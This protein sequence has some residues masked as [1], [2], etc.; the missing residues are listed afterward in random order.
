M[1]S[2]AWSKVRLGG[3]I[4]TFSF[5]NN[6]LY[7][8]YGF[9]NPS[10]CTFSSLV[11]PIF[12]IILASSSTA[13]VSSNS[14]MSAMPSSCTCSTHLLCSKHHYCAVMI[15]VIGCSWSH[16]PNSMIISYLCASALSQE[17]IHLS[18]LV[19]ISSWIGGELYFPPVEDTS[20]LN[21]VIISGSSLI[22]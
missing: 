7:Y 4:S 6:S 13:T 9:G 22:S 3:S 10:R 12:P 17:T 1:R 21:A 15:F 11:D 2:I 18:P 14:N 5:S 19:P 20:P 8:Q 16:H